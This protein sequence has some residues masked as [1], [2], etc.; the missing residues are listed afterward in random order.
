MQVC[1]YD[2]GQCCYCALYINKN[3]S[4]HPD[5]SFSLSL[6]L[7]FDIATRSSSTAQPKQNVI[8]HMLISSDDVEHDM[9]SMEKN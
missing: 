5:T 9:N 3:V 2:K 4:A 6:Y 7:F 8:N 1:G